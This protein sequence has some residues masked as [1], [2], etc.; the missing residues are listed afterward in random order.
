[1]TA[2]IL[3]RQG[4][5]VP[6]IYGDP[7]W[8]LP[9]IIPPAPVKQYELGVIVHLSELT[10]LSDT[11]S[12]KPN[13]IRYQIPAALS[14]SIRIITTITQP[15]FEALAAR[16]QEITACKRIVSTSLHGLVIAETYGIPCACLRT[17]GG[18]TTFV[19]LDDLNQR[20]DW[21]VRDFYSGMAVKNLFL[22]GQR[23]NQLTDWEDVI[24]AIDSYWEPVT[25]SPQTFLDAFPL[26]LAFNPLQGEKFSNHA[27][28]QQIK[29]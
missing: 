23:R 11:A 8:F 12:V 10:E 29:L 21:R 7:V 3:R 27:L 2:R 19:D 18:G 6:N 28:L 26:P 17:L 5:D 15:S 22:Y 13:L 20:I 1:M 14:S 4:L 9:A 16:V 25:W 24:Q